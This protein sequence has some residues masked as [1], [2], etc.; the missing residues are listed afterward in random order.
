MTETTLYRWRRI[1]MSSLAASVA[2]LG[3]RLAGAVGFVYTPDEAAFVRVDDGAISRPGGACP[4]DVFEAR[5]FTTDVELRWWHPPDSAM[6]IGIAVVVSESDL[7]LDAGEW[8][9]LGDAAG[10]VGTLNNRYLLWGNARGDAAAPGWS[11]L[12]EGRIGWLDVPLDRAPA[13]ARVRLDTVEYVDVV[14]SYGNRDVV[15]ERFVRLIAD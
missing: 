6:N 7:A 10:P 2:A 3:R 8:T 5:V 11:R 15:D 12:A 13:G 1:E 4:D 14:D 9:P